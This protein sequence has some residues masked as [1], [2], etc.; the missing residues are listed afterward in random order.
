[1][2]RTDFISQRRKNIE[3]TLTD[4][5]VNALYETERPNKFS[6]KHNSEPIND[7]PN[8]SMQQEAGTKADYESNYKNEP[9]K[10]VN[11]APEN[12]M[13]ESVKAIKRGRPSNEENGVNKK[14]VTYSILTSH[15]RQI[16]LVSVETGKSLSDIVDEAIEMYISKYYPTY[17]EK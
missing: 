4:D 15:I 3:D 9:E 10:G 2:A 1:M 6:K 5:V 17:K 11:E 7:R 16:K 8:E 12:T 14:I 13:T